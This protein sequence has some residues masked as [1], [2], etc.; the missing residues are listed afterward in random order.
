MVAVVRVV[1]TT[2]RKNVMITMMVDEEGP[3][4]ED[5][6]EE[7][8][9]GLATERGITQII[10]IQ[11]NLTIVTTTEVVRLYDENGADHEAHSTVIVKTSVVETVEIRAG[12]R[13]GNDIQQGR[14]KE[15]Q[16]RIVHRIGLLWHNCPTNHLN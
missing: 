2:G 9:G 14:T 3:T 6:F 8:E 15:D 11:N 1:G 16:R 10:G 12:T 4:T 13:T 5:R 7:E